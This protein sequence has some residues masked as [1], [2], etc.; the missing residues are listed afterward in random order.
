MAREACAGRQPKTTNLKEG[1]SPMRRVSSTILVSLFLT[2]AAYAQNIT[3]SMSGRVVDQQGTAVPGA[4]V[5]A[6]EPSK[7]LNIT[8]KSTESGEFNLAGLQPGNYTIEVVASGFKKLERLNVPLDAQDKL[9]LGDLLLEVGAVT[10]SIEVSAQ[11]VLLQTDSVERGQAIVGKQMDNIQVNGRNPLDMAKLI[12][13]VFSVANVS[14]GG[15]GGLSSVYVNGNRGTMNQLTING[16]G[17]IDTGADGSQNVTVSIDSMAEFKVLTGQYQA[18]Y[19]RN[20]GAQIAMVTKS[21]GNQFHGSGY[22]QH[23]HDDL[24]AN[25]FVNNV[26]GLP[27]ALYRYN[28]AGYTVGGPVYIPKL[29]DKTKNRLFFFWSQEWQEQLA[30]TAAKNVTVPTAL[31]RQGNFSQSVDNNG[32]ALAIRD[33]LTQ[34]PVPG[35]IIPPSQIYGPGQKLAQLLPLPNTSGTGYNYTSQVSAQTPRREDLLR[36]DYNV[37]Q[38]LHVFGHYIN[39]LQPV[40]NVYGA[41]VLGETVPLTG[42][43]V[44]TPGY[45]FAGGATYVISPTLTNEFN[46][47][48]TKNSINIFEQGNILTVAGSGV[49]LPLLY[50]SAQQDG[51]IPQ[52]QVNGTHL[53]N[54]PSLGTA[55]APFVNYN[56]TID[57]SDNLT[58]VWGKHI[59]KAGV[60]L[61]RSRKNQTSFNDN[62]GNYN[63]GDTTANPYDTG[64]GYSNML[65]GVYQTFDQSSGYINGMYRYWN[66]EEFVQDTWKITPRIA[67]DYGLRGSWYQPQYDASLQASTFVLANFNPANA[68]KLFTPA[69]NPANNQ[70]SAYNP[71]TN[72][73]YPAADIGLEIPG[74]GN[75]Y[76]GICQADKGGCNKYLMK[77]RGEQWGP[78]FGVAWDVFGNSRMVIR[79]GGGIYYDRYQGNRIFNNV[80]NP[81][82]S[83]QPTL[84]YGFAQQINPANAFL[85][86]P[87]VI[88][89]DPTGKVPTTYNYQF[90]IQNKLPWNLVLDT[91]YVGT[92]GRH[93]QDNRNLNG[94]PYGATF[95]PQNQ[96]PTLVAANPNALLGNNALKQAFLEPLQGY[97]S[98]TVYEGATNS[99]YNGLQVG[100]NRRAGNGLFL[101]VSYSYSKTM[102]TASSDTTSVRIDQ[103]TKEADYGPASFDVAHNFLLNYV[104]LIPGYRNGNYFLKSITSGWQLSGVS[105]F[106]TGQPFTPGFSVSGAGSV[107]QTGSYTEGARIG[108]VPGCN[109]Y[110]GSSDPFNRLN[111]ACFF[112]PPVG[113]TGLDSGVYFIR[114]PGLINFDMSLQKDIAIKE[115]FHIQLRVDAF[116]VFNHANFP[117]LNTT[118]NFNAYP[119]V[120]GIVNGSPTITST[121]LGRNANGSFNVTG[122]GTVV[123]PAAGAPGGPRVVQL[124]A[125]FTF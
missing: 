103:Y 93:L 107:N 62:N 89:M 84:Y 82:E 41:F 10:E 111:A 9:A 38:N 65:Y 47:G 96:D 102:T 95:L 92:Q 64:Y 32:K 113:S 5:S 15:V 81:P 11:Q 22:F 25:T 1:V 8:T 66:I 112:A 18:E 57:I 17:D 16:I 80:N 40:V 119:N 74:T 2:V 109:F 97:T 67:L 52:L 87:S 68:P 28:D 51:Y 50:P 59:V 69:I 71:I 54:Q 56:T 12:P 33:P 6:I 53:A 83:V 43:N 73:Y 76:N 39:N 45:S 44:V 14:V 49:N 77:N 114:Y 85:A 46:L 37:T 123:S 101:G 21:G 70:R 19:G 100:L 26:R 125:H 63:W 122:F 118:L 104:Y 120:N 3:G 55:D 94:I 30:P 110:T 48:M 121:A 36:M 91:A 60:Y 61:Q 105:Q 115:R 75:P 20:A 117:S 31:E 24:N 42:I 78:R 27:R 13:G 86:P 106:R 72:T 7:K 99:N 98:V 116:N 79:T 4:T 23:R 108:V 90:S 124:V 29:Y 88:A 58:K 35:N 34:Q